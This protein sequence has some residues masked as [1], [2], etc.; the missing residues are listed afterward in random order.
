MK[1]N[2]K[3][4]NQNSLSIVDH[5]KQTTALDVSN[6]EIIFL[7]SASFIAEIEE[8]IDQPLNQ[9]SVSMDEQSS[10]HDSKLIKDDKVITNYDYIC[11]LQNSQNSKNVTDSFLLHTPYTNTNEFLQQN[12]NSA[13]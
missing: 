13:S 9:S 7:S 5:D 10:I 6:D 8:I 11:G 4:T 12:S 2:N 3:G 1:H